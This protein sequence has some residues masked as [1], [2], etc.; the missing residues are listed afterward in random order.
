MIDPGTVV[1]REAAGDG[2]LWFEAPSGQVVARRP[3]QVAEALARLTAATDAGTWAA[4]WIA[5]E[6]APGLDPARAQALAAAGVAAIA[7]SLDG[8]ALRAALV[9][10]QKRIYRF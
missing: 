6:A 4:G 5:Y 9:C 8:V 7:N 10:N 3:D 2:W 1:M